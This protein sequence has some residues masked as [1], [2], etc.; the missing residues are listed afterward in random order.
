[1]RLYPCIYIFLVS[2][3]SV[4]TKLVSD[5][6]YLVSDLSYRRCSYCRSKCIVRFMYWRLV[7][8]RRQR[9][10]R[11]VS[12]ML[13][14]VSALSG[15]ASIRMKLLRAE[16]VE[17]MLQQVE[18]VPNY[19]LVL[20]SSKVKEG[21]GHQLF[22]SLISY[23]KGIEGKAPNK[24]KFMENCGNMPGPLSSLNGRQMCRLHE[25][26]NNNGHYKIIPTLE[27]GDC[28]YGS[29]RRCTTLP[30]ECADMHVRRVVIKVICSA[31][32]FFFKLFRKNIAD[33]YGLERDTPEE[34]AAKKAADKPDF[35]YI[36]EQELPGPFSF[37]QWLRHQMKASTY[38]D[39]NILMAISMLWQLR[40]TVLNAEELF[41]IRFRHHCRI[42]KADMVFIHSSSTEHYVAAGKRSYYIRKRPY[43]F[44]QRSS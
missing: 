33:T 42:S 1:M 8:K 36:R 32:Q 13:I 16:T 37:A 38:A 10:I 7:G 4:N 17:E 15:C 2:V 27:D 39:S 11:F 24:F 14:F 18:K 41:E 43:S 35:Q 6:S 28:L 19:N 31:P 29:F 44:R 22:Q 23:P 20:H 34:L 26:I 5:Y 21:S 12:A 25:F 3:V 9:S 40:V 30:A